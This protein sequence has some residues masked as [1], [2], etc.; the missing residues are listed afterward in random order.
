MFYAGEYLKIKLTM[1]QAGAYV[2]T[3]ACSNPENPAPPAGPFPP[4]DPGTP[5]PPTKFA[6]LKPKSLKHN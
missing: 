1:L 2:P 5:P 3:Y 4:S 6:I